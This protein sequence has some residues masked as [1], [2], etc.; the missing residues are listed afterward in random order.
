MEERKQLED[1]IWFTRISR[2]K[3]EKRLIDKEAFIQAINI[4]YSLIS[5]ICSIISFAYGDEK[6]GLFTIII[7]IGLLVSIL[8][9]NGQRYGDSARD[10]R[11]NYT[12]LQQLEMKLKNPNADL[13]GIRERY[14]QLL[15]TTSNHIEFDYWRAVENA[16]KEYKN[17][18]DWDGIKKR[19][20]WGKAWRLGVKII[21]I[22]LPIIILALCEVYA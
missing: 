12:E 2:T 16:S 5:I 19:L 13:E 1:Q 20:F 18:K 3:A 15:N 9:L 14:C 4:Y 7:T 6:M 11:K 10:Y 8:Y 22:I 17:K 21:V